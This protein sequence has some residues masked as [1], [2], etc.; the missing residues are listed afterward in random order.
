MG[1]ACCL[2]NFLEYIIGSNMA[3]HI[4]DNHIQ[5]YHMDVYRS[6]MLGCKYLTSPDYSVVQGWIRAVLLHPTYSLLLVPDVHCFF[7]FFTGLVRYFHSYNAIG[8]C[9][10]LVAVFDEPHFLL[11]P[12]VPLYRSNCVTQNFNLNKHLLY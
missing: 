1:A 3:L 12:H 4:S 11:S 7:K 2:F 8:P 9:H 6:I 5:F 10:Q